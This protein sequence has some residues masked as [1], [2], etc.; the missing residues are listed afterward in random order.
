[1]RCWSMRT[2]VHLG[3]LCLLPSC[4]W[5]LTKKQAF[6][7][8]GV[9]A[10]RHPDGGLEDH[11]LKCVPWQEKR[12]RKESFS[13]PLARLSLRVLRS[14]SFRDSKRS[15][16]CIPCLRITINLQRRQSGVQSFRKFQR[17]RIPQLTPLTWL[18]ELGMRKEALF[19]W[20]ASADVH[21][22]SQRVLRNL[23]V[24]RARSA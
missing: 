14:Y 8:H 12:K 13:F 15:L 9:A 10:R 16:S 4:P 18:S 24:L 3:S 23:H 19:I 7:W 2:S 21:N 17:W 22:Y 6:F 5:S 11:F 20:K 1:M